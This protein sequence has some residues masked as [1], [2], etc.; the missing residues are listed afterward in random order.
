MSTRRTPLPVPG[1]RLL[2]AAA[3]GGMFIAGLA[4]PAGAEQF[5]AT[6]PSAEPEGVGGEMSSFV[7]QHDREVS[8]QR[9]DPQDFMESLGSQES[10]EGESAE[11]IVLETDIL[12]A[13]MEWEVPDG[14]GSEVAELIAEVPD[15]AVV[16]VHGHTDST[17][18]PEH[19]GFDN[20]E[21]S[22]NRA[23]A[24]ADVLREVR[25]DLELDVSGQG[26]GQP[27]VQED[28]EDPS[29]L[30][31]NRRVETAYEN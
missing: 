26:A 5:G 12:F 8:I 20:Q 7:E 16:A 11:V 24:V 6:G 15:G 22:E 30:A 13:T 2:A 28:P 3:S 25:A 31:E 1:V 17:P 27:A 19:Y 21:L 23:E 14:A 18:V 10:G 29:T 9:Y 4:A